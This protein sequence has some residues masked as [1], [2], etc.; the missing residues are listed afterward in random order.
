MKG[1]S[2]EKVSD[3]NYR[4]ATHEEDANRRLASEAVKILLLPENVLPIEYRKE[5]SKLKLLIQSTIQS[6]PPGLIPVRLGKIRK[7]T[8]VKYIKLLIDIQIYF[9]NQLYV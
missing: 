7:S 9:E 8:A 3:I 4:I 6:S 5:F 1:Y 2:L